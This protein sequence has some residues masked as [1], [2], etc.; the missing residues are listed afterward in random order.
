MKKNFWNKLPKSHAD[1]RGKYFTCLAPM[2]G[3]TD[4]PFR[5]IL[6]EIGKPD[7]IFTEFVSTEMIVRSVVGEPLCGLPKEGGHAGPPLRKFRKD[8]P[9]VLAFSK[10]QRPIVVQFFGSRPEQ[11]EYCAA[12]AV[13]LKF[14]GVDINMGCPDRKV[15]KQGAGSEL[16]KNPQ[17]AGKIIQAAKKGCG[18][19]LPISVKTR[20][21]YEKKNLD[22]IQFLLEQGLDAL[23][24]HGRVAK[25][26]YG[27]EADWEAIGEA[28]KMRDKMKLKTLIIGN[29]DVK[30]LEQGRLLAGKYGIDGFMIG[31]QALHNSWIFKKGLIN[32]TPTVR[33]RVKVALKHTQLFEKF[34][35]KKKDFGLMKKYYKAYLSGTALKKELM[36]CKNIEEVKKFLKSNK[37]PMTKSQ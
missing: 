12:L 6:C 18:G 35:G 32:Q 36:G 7:V 1:W 33:G 29:G 30:S 5:E 14:G 34:Y 31:R 24:I 27:G 11:F 10:K 3:V 19:K 28:V 17:L 37:T 4:F 15:L 26:G 16:I 2:S 8:L 21:G 20:L 23:T 25:Q 9:S 22:W 13:K